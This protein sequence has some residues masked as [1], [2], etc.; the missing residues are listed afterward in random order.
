MYIN[1]FESCDFTYTTAGKV[2]FPV[3][4]LFNKNR[5][6]LYIPEETFTV[7]ALNKAFKFKV[8]SGSDITVTLIEGEY[9]PAA[10]AAHL[11]TVFG[12]GF[13]CEYD[14]ALRKFKLKN[15]QGFILYAAENLASWDMI[16]F[17]SGNTITCLAFT[18][19][20]ADE[21]RRHTEIKIT[22]DMGASAYCGFFALLGEKNKALGLSE[23]ATVNLKLSSID[24]YASAP[25][26]LDMT[27]NER[28]IF[29]FIDG[30]SEDTNPDYRYVWLTIRDREN[31][32]NDNLVFSQCFLGPYTS[33]ENRTI[34]NGFNMKYV[35]LS[36]KSESISG[37][38]Y[39][40]RHGRRVALSS[41]DIQYLTR[42]QAITLRQ[43][44]F[45][46]GTSTHLY[47]SLDAGRIYDDPSN[48]CF[49]GILD[50]EIDVK[51]EPPIYFNGSF[52]FVED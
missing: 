17:A 39:F 2:G 48:L 45:D 44:S 29:A 14:S 5:A 46:L 12:W 21:I 11:Q 15:T 1:N 38:M 24:D 7:T 26:S 37:G 19:Y 25:I 43:L 36:T 33:F 52:S 27:Y 8:G 30:V 10:L 23:G 9:L 51:H 47:L 40:N 16:G 4:N 34:N 18:W 41:L 49:Y 3:S 31:V 6:S 50:S 35:D 42:D 28:G 22:A 32:A 13:L 20:F